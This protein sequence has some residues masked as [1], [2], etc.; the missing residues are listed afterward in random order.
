MLNPVCFKARRSKGVRDILM[1]VH[2]RRFRIEEA[3]SGD[4]QMPPEVEAEVGPMH[5]EIMS[6]LRAIRAQM[7]VSRPSS[8]T[9]ETIGEAA[10]REVAEAHA[11]LETYRA[12]IEQCEKLKVELDLI[13]NPITPPNPESAYMH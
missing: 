3:I 6:E 1:P 2:R 4:I 12:Q 10:S 8:V 13:Y 9:T 5:L 7:A 11:L